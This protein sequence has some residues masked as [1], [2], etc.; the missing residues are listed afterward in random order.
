MFYIGSGIFF[1][2]FSTILILVYETVF[3]IGL[4]G[5]FPK[6]VQSAAK[7]FEQLKK[8]LSKNLYLMQF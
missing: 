3:P 5:N 1:T 4:L 7:L 2:G 8:F 6:T